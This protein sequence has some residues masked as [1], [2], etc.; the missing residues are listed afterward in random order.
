[1]N[2]NATEEEKMAERKRLLMQLKSTYLEM[3]SKLVS[4][5]DAVERL[6]ELNGFSFY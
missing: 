6:Y 4:M 2:A 1:M 5:Q 3:K